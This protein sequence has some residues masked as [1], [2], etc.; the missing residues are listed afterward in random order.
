MARMTISSINSPDLSYV[1]PDARWPLPRTGVP[2]TSRGHTSS[3][4]AM[5][6]MT[7]SSINSP[8]LSYVEPDA[9]WPLPRT[10]VPLTSRGHTSSHLAMAGM[11]ISSNYFPLIYLCDAYFTLAEIMT[12]RECEHGHGKIVLAGQPNGVG[13]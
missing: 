11:T 8:D 6:R 13:R 12:N 3:H 2:L 4:L 1:E 9:R 7:I 5:A 10:G